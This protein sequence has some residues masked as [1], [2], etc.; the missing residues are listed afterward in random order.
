MICNRIKAFNTFK[1]P[2][3]EEDSKYKPDIIFYKANTND[4]KDCLT[5]QRMEMFVEFK[6]GNTSNPFSLGTNTY[7]LIR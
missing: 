1:N 4:S 6:R 2:S 3:S 5:F 7:L